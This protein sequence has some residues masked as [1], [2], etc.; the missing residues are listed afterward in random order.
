MTNELKSKYTKKTPKEALEPPDEQLAPGY[1][2]GREDEDRNFKGR[3]PE[4]G[5]KA[6]VLVKMRKNIHPILKIGS[7]ARLYKS[8]HGR[9]F[10]K[11]VHTISKI[12]TKNETSRYFVNGSWRDRDQILLV[13]GTDAETERQVAEK[14]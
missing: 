11:R 6:R 5:D 9:H 8:Y 2:K 4:V 1:K 7:Q 10:T 3:K 12:L 13:S 14:K